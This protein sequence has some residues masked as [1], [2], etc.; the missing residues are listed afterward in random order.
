MPGPRHSNGRTEIRTPTAPILRWRSSRSRRTNI[1]PGRPESGRLVWPKS[2]SAPVHLPAAAGIIRI[3]PLT[4]SPA[5]PMPFDEKTEKANR[6]KFEEMLGLKTPLREG[7]AP[8]RV[9]GTISLTDNDFD[10]AVRDHPVMVVDFWAPWCAPCNVVSPM[11]D[12]LASEFAGRVTFAKLNVDDNPM[13]AATMGIQSI[14]T[15][16]IFKNGRPV[17]GVI[18]AVPKSQVERKIRTHLGEGYRQSSPYR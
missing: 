2:G 15:I 4:V 6:E 10:Q 14:P 11:L 12:E 17:D 8:E 9:G 18:G 16:L 3:T 5:K 1:R 13:V 7:G